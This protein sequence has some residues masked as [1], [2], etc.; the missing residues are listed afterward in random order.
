MRGQKSST[1]AAERKP[2]LQQEIDMMSDGVE[3]EQS[4]H[5][6]KASG[7]KGKAGNVMLSGGT[8]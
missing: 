7:N 4:E 8:M 5:V 6:G 1:E 3:S 2:S